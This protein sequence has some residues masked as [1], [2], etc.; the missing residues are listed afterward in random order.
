MLFKLFRHELRF[1]KWHRC[2]KPF[3]TFI[4]KNSSFLEVS[5]VSEHPE[6][7]IVVVGPKSKMKDLFQSRSLRNSAN[8]IYVA[9]DAPPLW[10]RYQP[11]RRAKTPEDAV[12]GTDFG[13]W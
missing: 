2:C 10:Q 4:K 7:Y 1:I 12:S 5:A 11:F 13:L 8:V 9:L 3:K 6:T